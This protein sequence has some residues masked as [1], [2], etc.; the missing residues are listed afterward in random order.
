MSFAK[1]ALICA[2]AALSLSACGTVN[3]KPAVSPSSPYASR[4]RVDDPRTSKNNHVACLEAAKIPVREIGATDL[5]VGANVRVR[6]EPTSGAA[7]ADQ[8]QDHE[9]NAEVI[10]SALVYP[11]RAPDAELTEIE[12]CIALGVKG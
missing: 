11:D 1:A 2:T 7:Q 8:F 5:L 10:G 3:V 4:G 9:Q 6:F 12:R